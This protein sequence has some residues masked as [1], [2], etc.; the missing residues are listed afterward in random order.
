MSLKFNLSLAPESVLFVNDDDDITDG[1]SKVTVAKNTWGALIRCQACPK[2]FMYILS[3]L[4][5]KFL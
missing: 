4:E 3:L 5:I 2:L 1:N